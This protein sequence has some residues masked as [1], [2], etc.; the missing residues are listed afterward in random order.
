MSLASEISD[1]QTNLAA[2][3]AAI[4]ADGGTV[5]DTGLAG[6][7]TEIGT[8]PSGG[9][10][11]V[12]VESSY[13]VLRYY[14][15]MA[16]EFAIDQY[17]GCDVTVSNN[18]TF[19]SFMTTNFT[20]FDNVQ[21]QYRMSYPG[22]DEW[23]FSAF[24][25]DTMQE[26]TVDVATADMPATAGLTV[27][28]YEDWATIQIHYATVV[29]T[30]SAVNAVVLSSQSEYE[31]LYWTMSEH[32][33]IEGIDMIPERVEGFFFGNVPTSVPNY[34]LGYTPNLKHL[35]KMP[36][37]YTTIGNNFLGGSGYVGEGFNIVG[38]YV[39][40]IGTGFISGANQSA[41]NRP[42]F[43]SPITLTRVTSVGENFLSYNDVFNSSVD[44]GVLQTIG[45]SFF[46]SLTAFDK[47]ITVPS[48]LVID[49]QYL[50]FMAGLENMTHTI[51]MDAALPAFTNNWW[52]TLNTNTGA[53]YS[54]GI[55]LA[56]T[57]AQD[58]KNALPN[59]TTSP[60]RN[61]A[62]ASS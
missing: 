15:G 20:G 11:V 55:K 35:S 39:T 28:P 62:L 48:T 16:S 30:T 32:K 10:E 27:T 54:Q 41:E 42:Q 24:N 8:I 52:L 49:R 58:W 61:L 50:A 44:L 25:M 31:K 37:Q 12:V 21:C 1:L 43:N 29:D 6:L 34:F 19:Q 38:D 45:N 3:K 14:S 40:T 33:T 13:G 4:T 17:Q 51:T 60:Y 2:A 23:R 57:Y 36:S 7:S 22:V 56:G 47:D 9:E 53:A 26:V 5:G 46:T 18:T 59:S